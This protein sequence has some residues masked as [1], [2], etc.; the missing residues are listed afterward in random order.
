[1]LLFYILLSFSISSFFVCSLSNM[2]FFY[3]HHLIYMLTIFFYLLFNPITPILFFVFI[4]QYKNSYIQIYTF[5]IKGI[6]I[7]F[8]YFKRNL[9]TLRSLII[10]SSTAAPTSPSEEF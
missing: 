8:F 5:N 3:M 10:A 1:M 7:S 2:L 6:S 4:H 9:T